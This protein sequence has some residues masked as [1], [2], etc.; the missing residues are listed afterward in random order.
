M[1][2]ERQWSDYL[3][4]DNIGGFTERLRTLLANKRFTFIS[5]N[6]GRDNEPEVRINQQLR[7]R[8]PRG[9]RR[10]PD[11][12]ASNIALSEAE[13]LE[14]FSCKGQF[15][16]LVDGTVLKH[17]IVTVCDSYGVWSVSTTLTDKMLQESYAGVKDGL[18]VPPA[19]EEKRKMRENA[20]YFNFEPAMRDQPER[21]TITLKSGSGNKIHW[22]IYPE[23]VNAE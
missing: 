17:Q 12:D 15:V 2:T 18:P 7:G 20:T 5:V 19:L 3:T 4:L 1:N 10:S 21:V 22:L 9:G 13:T 16:T 8:E 14:S 23:A 6:S 11:G